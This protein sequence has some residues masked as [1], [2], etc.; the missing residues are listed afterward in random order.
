MT[1]HFETT[2]TGLSA[3]PVIK[4]TPPKFKAGDRTSIWKNCQVSTDSGALLFI[5]RL[6]DS[7]SQTKAE[8][9]RI[10]LRSRNVNH[11]EINSV[12]IRA[13]KML[14]LLQQDGTNKWILRQHH[15]ASSLSGVSSIFC[16][17]SCS[18]WKYPF[19]REGKISAVWKHHTAKHIQP[20]DEDQTG[21][22]TSYSASAN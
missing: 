3:T 6:N 22:D 8:H 5:M 12:F 11:S 13:R 1:A 18:V 15:P 19:R 9:E 14:L 7:L 2:V 17:F 4:T 21:L 20:G 10:S 16:C